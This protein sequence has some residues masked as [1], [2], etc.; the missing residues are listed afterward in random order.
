MPTPRP[1]LRRIAPLAAAL[2]AVALGGCTKSSDD[3]PPAPAYTSGALVSGFGSGG[4][5][6]TDPS[7]RGDA[8]GAA[9]VVGGD[10][11]MVVGSDESVS[12]GDHRWRIE[13]W[14]Y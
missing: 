8:V 2:L 7:T 10:R 4:I 5:A 14:C 11:L 12:A 1:V 3:A 6:L 13:K 9:L